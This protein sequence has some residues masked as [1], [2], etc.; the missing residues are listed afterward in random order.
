LAENMKV[1]ATSW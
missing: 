1:K